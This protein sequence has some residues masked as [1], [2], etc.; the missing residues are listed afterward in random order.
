MLLS[1]YCGLALWLVP[2]V[3]LVARTFTEMLLRVACDG[4]HSN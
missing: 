4:S 3:C 1:M 2:R